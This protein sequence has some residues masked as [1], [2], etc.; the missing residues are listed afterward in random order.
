MRRPP[1]RQRPRHPRRQRPRHPCGRR[2]CR[3][4]RKRRHA[5]PG[6]RCCWNSS[7]ICARSHR[8]PRRG[9]TCDA[10][11]ASDRSAES[12]T[13]RMGCARTIRVT[14][15]KSRIC[16]PRRTR[17]MR[18][19]SCKRW[20]LRLRA[21]R[22]RSPGWFTPVRG[23]AGR[24]SYSRIALR[25]GACHRVRWRECAARQHRSSRRLAA[26]LLPRHAVSQ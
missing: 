19:S 23:F 13:G 6:A 2:A 4:Q 20:M 7:D 21:R 5:E 12:R 15:S 10:S 11:T 25:R 3:P 16:T 9:E 17:P 18:S 14:N 26:H 24:G 8:A 22:N 1:R